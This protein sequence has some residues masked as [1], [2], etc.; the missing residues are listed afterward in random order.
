MIEAGV[1]QPASTNS[2]VRRNHLSPAARVSSTASMNVSPGQEP[3]ACVAT[4]EEV[5]ATVQLVQGQVITLF[6]NKQHA[7][8]ITLRNTSVGALQ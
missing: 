5:I 8:T 2:R 4:P 1:R 3:Y 7:K 6:G